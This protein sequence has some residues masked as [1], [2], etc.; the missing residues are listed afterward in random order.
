[1]RAETR[2]A[3]GQ[4]P[5]SAQRSEGAAPDGA[6]PARRRWP[7]AGPDRDAG[8]RGAAR[9]G[10]GPGQGPPEPGDHPRSEPG[11]PRRAARRGGVGATGA[12]AAAGTATIGMA[13]P[14]ECCTWSDPCPAASRT[15]PP[16]FVTAHATPRATTTARPP[17]PATQRLSAPH[18]TN[19]PVAW[20]ERQARHR[21]IGMPNSREV[22]DGV[23]SLACTPAAASMSRTCRVVGHRAARPTR[24]RL[25]RPDRRTLHASAYGRL[26]DPSGHTHHRACDR[27]GPGC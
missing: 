15:A 21:I 14:W 4:R 16:G 20:L 1:M 2:G 25:G 13:C 3:L 27:T 24:R 12:Y 7:R 23:A 9:A 11:G 8:R 22:R 18:I 6:G 5:P 19:P 26:R 10:Q 17:G